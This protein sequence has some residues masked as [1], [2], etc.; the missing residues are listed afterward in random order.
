MKHSE[1]LFNK[2]NEIVKAKLP[3]IVPVPAKRL[4]GTAFFPA[5]DGV[6]KEG[7]WKPRESYPIMVV[8]QDYDNEKNF[9]I[10]LKSKT[11]SEVSNSN[12]T[13]INLKR[14]LGEEILSK[15]FFT[16]AIMGLRFEDSKNTGVSKAFARGDNYETFLKENFTFFKDQ[17]SIM[18]PEL[19][20]CLGAQLPRFIGGCFPEQFPD[21][22]RVRSFK[23]LDALP[24]KSRY[25]L[26]YRGG[27]ATLIFITHPALYDANVTR[28]LGGKGKAFES[29]YLKE[30]ISKF[31]D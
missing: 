1:A 7:N 20:I 12:K 21:L 3:E 27:E 6:Y 22:I 14:L 17:L 8:G 2:L 19:V 9:G 28:R 4:K 24:E 31:S 13:W 10:V 23:D 26:K 11:Q 15:C 5:G 18:R 30:E 16:N 25:T 29:K